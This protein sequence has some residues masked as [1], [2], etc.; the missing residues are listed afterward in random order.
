MRELSLKAVL[1]MEGQNVIIRDLAYDIYD[2][3]CVINFTRNSHGKVV[4]IF[5]INEEYVCQQPTTQAKTLKWGLVKALLISLSSTRTTLRQ[6]R[7]VRQDASQVLTS[8]D[9]H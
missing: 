9:M 3:E 4:K 7:Q 6:N 8:T 5:F 2:Q 1:C